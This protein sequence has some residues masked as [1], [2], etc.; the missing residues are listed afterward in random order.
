MASLS[1]SRQMLGCCIKFGPN[2]S[3]YILL[4]VFSNLSLVWCC[5][6]VD[7][8]LTVGQD[9]SS[10][11]L[12]D[13]LLEKNFGI[14]TL[15]M[16]VRTALQAGRS[17]FRFPMGSRPALLAYYTMGTGYSQGLNGRGVVLTTHPH[18]APRLKKEK[19]CTSAPPSGTSWPVLGW[20]L[21]L[22]LSIWLHG[23]EWWGNIWV[24]NRKRNDRGPF[25]V[26]SW[27]LLERTEDSHENMSLGVAG[28]L[29]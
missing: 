27:H 17:R 24:M 23:I 16:G 21:S 11:M 15:N 6:E 7:T 12:V 10:S 4:N 20:T 14:V 29:G 5:W 19:S 13:I 18:L 2:A 1:S 8:T 28:V 25:N 26:F 9:V 22:P 3:L